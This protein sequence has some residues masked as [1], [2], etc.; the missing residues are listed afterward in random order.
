MANSAFREEEA[1]RIYKLVEE[2]YDAII[3]QSRRSEFLEHLNEIYSFLR[4]AERAT[5][6]K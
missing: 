3:P 5:N 2:M 6:A 1:A 4:A